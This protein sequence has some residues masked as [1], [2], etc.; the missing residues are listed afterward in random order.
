MFPRAPRA[1]VYS[2]LGSP[3]AFIGVAASAASPALELVEDA[4]SGVLTS[5][6]SHDIG[7][8]HWD[9]FWFGTRRMFGDTLPHDWNGAAVEAF[10]WLAEA[11]G[12][13]TYHKRARAIA[14]QLLGLF[15]S[16]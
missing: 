4:Q 14:R 16:E 5:W 12:N 11:T 15:D 7:L 6:H 2:I 9:G 8:H 3:L 13:A 10:M 1:D